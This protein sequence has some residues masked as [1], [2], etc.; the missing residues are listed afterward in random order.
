MVCG[1]LGFPGLGLVLGVWGSNNG[2]GFE[3]LTA[4][5]SPKP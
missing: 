5:E 3:R 4:T 1:N 2:I